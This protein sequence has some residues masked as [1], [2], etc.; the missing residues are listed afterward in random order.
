M[1]FHHRSFSERKKPSCRGLASSRGF[2]YIELIIVVAVTALLS[3]AM[4]ANMQGAKKTSQVKAAADSVQSGIRAAQNSALAGEK[5]PNGTAA[6]DFGW[7]ITSI[8]ATSFTI[9]VEEVGGANKV[10][11]ETFPLPEFVQIQ[12]L[13][14]AGAAKTS[15]AVRFFPPFGRLA[16]TTQDYTEAGNLTATFQ[17]TYQGTSIIR[18]ITIDGISGR[19]S[20]Q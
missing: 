6:R 4:V 1:H 14:V 16:M 17:I 7:E 8:P 3:G 2:T 11:L 18:T 20:T 12:N 13:T 5:H 19:I 15:L 10:V 9:F